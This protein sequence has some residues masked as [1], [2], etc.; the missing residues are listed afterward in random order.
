MDTPP[1]VS[2][3]LTAPAQ[4]SIARLALLEQ[5]DSPFLGEPKPALLAEV[6]PS[7]Y[8]Y[9]LETADAVVAVR[10]GTLKERA[11]LWA[12]AL[13]HDA[14]LKKVDALNR[15][16]SDFFATLPRPEEEQAKKV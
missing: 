3:G 11:L 8:L 7:L 2:R 10:E 9:E 4:L 5:I 13:T 6:L 1:I 12:D 14:Y 15:A 16:I